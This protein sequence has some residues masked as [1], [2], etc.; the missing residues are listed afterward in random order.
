LFRTLCA[1]L[2][3]LQEVML[4]SAQQASAAA[5]AEEDTSAAPNATANLQDDAHGDEE[6]GEEEQA[7][8]DQDVD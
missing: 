4:T 7:E 1:F 2:L 3:R 5:K 8:D 6:Q